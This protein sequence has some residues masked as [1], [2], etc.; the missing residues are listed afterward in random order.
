[1]SEISAGTVAERISR[2]FETLTHAE[3]KLSNVILDNYPVSGLGTITALAET[4]EVSAPTV[5]RMARKL[6]YGG[7]PELQTALRTEL[8][9]TLSSPIT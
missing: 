4:A 5:A 1:M 2:L 6:G 8:E 7:F 3:R 9:A